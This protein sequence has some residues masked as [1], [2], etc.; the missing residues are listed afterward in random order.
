MRKEERGKKGKGKGQGKDEK[1]AAIY[2]FQGYCRTCGKW[3]HKASECWQGYVQ[4]VEEVPSSSASSVAPS[5]ATTPAAAENSSI[6]SRIQCWA[7][8]RMDLRRDGWISGISHNWYRQ[9]VGWACV[10]Q[11][12]S[13]DSMSVCLVFGHQFEQQEQ[14]ASARHSTTQNS[15]AWMKGGTSWIVGSRRLCWMQSQI[16]CCRCC[17]PSCF[18]GKDDWVRFHVQLWWLQVL[19]EQR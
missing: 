9:S 15:I 10:E 4:D 8:T 19:H 17:V 6:D 1:P 3:R 11:W 13:V 16:W 2:G 5:A 12:I 7:G 18:T 14:G